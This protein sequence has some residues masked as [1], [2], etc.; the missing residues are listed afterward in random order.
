VLRKSLKNNCANDLITNDNEIIRKSEKSGIKNRVLTIDQAIEMLSKDYP[1]LINTPVN[2]KE[3]HLYEIE[4]NDP[5]LDS[6]RTDYSNFDEWLAK[7]KAAQTKAWV[8][9]AQDN[10]KRL[11]A[12]LILKCEGKDEDDPSFDKPLPRESHLKISMLKVSSK[13]NKF[14]ELFIRIAVEEAIKNEIESIYVTVFPKQTALIDLLK[15]YGFTEYTWKSTQRGDGTLDKELVLLKELNTDVTSYPIIVYK[16]QNTFIVPIRREYVSSL[17]PGMIKTTQMNFDSFLDKSSHS[18]AIKKAYICNANS[19]QMKSED[20][21]FF[22]I[23]GYHKTIAGIGVIDDV[24]KAQDICSLDVFCKLVGQ[25]TVY[26]EGYLKKAY[27]N[28][29]LVILFKYYGE[30]SKPVS[31]ITLHDRNLLCG[32]PQSIQIINKN[33]ALEIFKLG[34]YNGFRLENS[35]D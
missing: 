34:K 6:F 7:K 4:N 32:Y 24:F 33:V 26:D 21:L 25:R 16:Q 17:F 11:G 23:S 19:K 29:M 1:I 15:E 10:P 8:S 9:Y 13:G 27:D 5:F 3:V 18:N 31:Y 35:H 2:V 28:N 22:Y 20:I 30:M 14:G 12:M